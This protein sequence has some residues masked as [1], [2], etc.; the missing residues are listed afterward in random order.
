MQ[1][2]LTHVVLPR[3]AR[4]TSAP[5]DG[6]E[7]SQLFA[8]DLLLSCQGPVV[9]SFFPCGCVF[10]LVPDRYLSKSIA[11][12]Q[13]SS[14]KTSSYAPVDSY[15][16][17]DFL[18]P[19]PVVLQRPHSSF[20]LSKSTI[21][22]P[23]PLKN[24]T[25]DDTLFSSKP[26][27]QIDLWSGI[28]PHQSAQAR[29]ID[30]VASASQGSFNRRR[31]ISPPAG[32]RSSERPHTSQALTRSLSPLSPSDSPQ[33]QLRAVASFSPSSGTLTSDIEHSIQTAERE[34]VSLSTVYANK[35]IG[36][37]VKAWSKDSV[38]QR[39]AP[40]VSPTS[41]K[42]SYPAKK[43]PRSLSPEQDMERVDYIKGELARFEQRLRNI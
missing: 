23:S 37:N 7:E 10:C 11:T 8:V 32:P 29:G 42:S 16:D 2:T 30:F 26:S 38:S 9:L 4:H 15:K 18:N 6:F 3:A 17:W 5:I 27:R 35:T 22:P 43:G 21:C 1:G 20:A 14:P 36:S 13:S 40:S 39:L 19:P 24:V 28:R 31:T 25:Y 34:F 41:P 12:M 33:S